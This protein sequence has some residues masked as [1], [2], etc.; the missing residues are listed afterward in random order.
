MIDKMTNQCVHYV[1]KCSCLESKLDE[2][3][4]A[5]YDAPLPLLEKRGGAL[6]RRRVTY[7]SVEVTL[8]AEA[9]RCLDLQDT[10]THISLGK[11][12]GHSHPPI[13]LGLMRLRLG[14]D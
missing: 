4:G 2:V 3:S 10:D 7:L 9:S 1:P 12:K 11:P 6:E 14:D 13:S 5:R 8:R